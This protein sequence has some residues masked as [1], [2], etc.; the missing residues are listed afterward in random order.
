MTMASLT[1]QFTNKQ[2]GGEGDWRR[3]KCHDKSD[4]LLLYNHVLILNVAYCWHYLYI[5]H[6]NTI[7]LNTDMYVCISSMSKAYYHI[8]LSW[9]LIAL[10]QCVIF[11]FTNL[12][13]LSLLSSDPFFFIFF[14]CR[15]ICLLMQ[16]LIAGNGC[17]IVTQLKFTV[18][19]D[20]LDCWAAV[21]TS[22]THGRRW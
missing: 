3:V 20:S 4:K 13:S 18:M 16:E 6:S 22:E 19:S 5:F 1:S 7:H 10:N 8:H 9:L 11:Y 17:V 15:L 14:I 2:F 12:C 21:M